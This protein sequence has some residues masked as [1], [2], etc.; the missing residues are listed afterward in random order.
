M[1]SSSLR[2]LQ[3]SEPV[4]YLVLSLTTMLIIIFMNS[5]VAGE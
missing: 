4:G 5:L 3:G 1:S 2:V